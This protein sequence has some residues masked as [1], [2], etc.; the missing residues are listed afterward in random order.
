MSTGRMAQLVLE[1]E[2]RAG[3]WDPCNSPVGDLTEPA[4]ARPACNGYIAG[5]PN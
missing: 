4:L 2:A 1:C 5:N 3:V